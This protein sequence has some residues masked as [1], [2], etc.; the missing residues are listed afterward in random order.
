VAPEVLAIREINI[1]AY[2]FSGPDF[3]LALEAVPETAGERYLTAVFPALR[4]RGRPIAAHPTADSASAIGVN[5]RLDLMAV[6]RRARTRLIEAHALAGVGFTVPESVHLDADVEIGEDTVIG[7]GVS[8]T[9]GTRIGRG[10]QVGP[11]T[12]AHATL[13]GDE[14]V[15]VHSYLVECEVGDRS[16]VGPFAYLRPGARLEPGAKAGTFVEVKNSTLGPGAKVP[17][18]SYVG[19]AEVGEGANLGAGTI[20]ANYDG[21]RKHRT[22]IGRG[23]RTGV[24]SSLVAPVRIGDEAYTAAGSA[25]T[26]DVPDGALGVAR[27]KQRNVEGYAERVRERSSR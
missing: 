2:A 21:R 11:H 15:A 17:H 23:V 14:V 24:H 19:D 20:T 13:I 12:S 16:S 7:P 9:G 18:L 4:A 3:L 27:S 22:V 1:G 5:T 10:C 8:L 26:G 25:I 6:E